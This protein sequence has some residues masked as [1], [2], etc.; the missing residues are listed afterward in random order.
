[1]GS[2]DLGGGSARGAGEIIGSARKRVGLSLLPDRVARDRGSGSMIR[3]IG[4]P[5]LRR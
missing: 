1:M 2:D 3:D 5:W 4:C